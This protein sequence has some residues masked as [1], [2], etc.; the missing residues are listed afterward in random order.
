MRTCRSCGVPTL[1]VYD[2]PSHLLHFFLSLLT[3]GLWLPIWLLVSV[4]RRPPACTRCG[5]KVGS[6]ELW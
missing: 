2:Q 3:L 5:K 6:F 1:H 4:V